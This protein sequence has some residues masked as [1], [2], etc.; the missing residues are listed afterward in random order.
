MN[1]DFFQDDNGEV[2]L[3]HAKDILV[4]PQIKSQAERDIEEDIL[5]S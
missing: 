1:C 5:K 3:F 2:W 4:R